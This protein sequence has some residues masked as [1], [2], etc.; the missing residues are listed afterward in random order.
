MLPRFPKTL[1][2]SND[3]F[4]TDNP[5]WRSRAE[6]ETHMEPFRSPNT[7]KIK[8]IEVT[9]KETAL[10]V[11]MSQAPRRDEKLPAQLHRAQV[12]EVLKSDRTQESP[13]S[14]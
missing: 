2:E 1:A 9:S 8:G 5:Y 13:P 4:L 11:P 10:W 7:G 3:P 14:S 12:V 6:R